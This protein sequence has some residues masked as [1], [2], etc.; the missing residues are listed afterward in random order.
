MRLQVEIEALRQQKQDLQQLLTEHKR[1]CR[2]KLEPMAD[3]IDDKS[4]VTIDPSL[5]NS[6]P[7]I[8]HT[9]TGTAVSSTSAAVIK[10]VQPAVRPTTLL[11]LNETVQTP[12]SQPQ[13]RNNVQKVEL[14]FDSLMDGGTGLT[15]V[16]SSTTSS[17]VTMQH[18]GSTIS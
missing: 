18:G 8:L 7:T 6:A 15:P 2:V 12:R 14:N 4:N 9:A 3:C 13:Q 16:T 1:Q 5:I 17:L 11:R 10:R